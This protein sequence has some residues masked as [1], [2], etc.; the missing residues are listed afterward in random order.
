MSDEKTNFAMYD[1]DRNTILAALRAYQANGY[2]EPANMPDWLFDIA[3]NEEET[4]SMDS[5]GIDDLCERL[6]Q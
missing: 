3:T 2:C 5:A 4:I 6:N 1:Q